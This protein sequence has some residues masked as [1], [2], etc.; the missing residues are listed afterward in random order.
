LLRGVVAARMSP[1]M[2]QA[3]QHP[4]IDER[5]KKDAM[6]FSCYDRLAP[7]VIEVSLAKKI[8]AVAN[9]GST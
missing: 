4:G 2:V 6:T 3:G 8:A 7:L 5:G 1:D 9:V